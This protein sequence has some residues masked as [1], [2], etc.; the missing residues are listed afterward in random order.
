MKKIQAW[1]GD[2]CKHIQNTFELYFENREI[3]VLS[4]EPYFTLVTDATPQNIDGY[5]YTLDGISIDLYLYGILY[6]IMIEFN[7]TLLCCRIYWEDVELDEED[8][9]E[10][11]YYEILSHGYPYEIANVLCLTPYECVSVIE[12][13]IIID[14]KNR[15]DDDD[16]GD[17]EDDEPVETGPILP[18]CNTPVPITI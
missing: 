3:Q 1:P 8:G 7:N 17:D 9:E 16:E 18:G 14:Y 6:K 4:N 13:A 10:E 12:K 11:Y 2:W 15:F 5:R